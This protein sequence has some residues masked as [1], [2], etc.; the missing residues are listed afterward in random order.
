MTRRLSS[1]IGFG[2]SYGLLLLHLLLGLRPDPATRTL[3]SIA[4]QELPAWL[5]TLTLSGVR[6]FERSWDVRLE[7]GHIE[8]KE[9]E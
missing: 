3:V 5:G 8:V 1:A 6:A 2:L 9:A 4:P 7:S